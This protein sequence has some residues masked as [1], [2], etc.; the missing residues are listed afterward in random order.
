MCVYLSGASCS[1]MS[2]S[3]SLLNCNNNNDNYKEVRHFYF[4]GYDILH[5][6]FTISEHTY[7]HTYVYTYVTQVFVEKLFA[8]Q[9]P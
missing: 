1:E 3:K 7:I 6:L 4:Y 9:K 5:P 8:K 2:L